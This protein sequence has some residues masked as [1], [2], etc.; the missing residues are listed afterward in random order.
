[1]APGSGRA[2]HQQRAA[3]RPP[4]GP[5]PAG[6]LAAVS[7]AGT[8]RL[9]GGRRPRPTSK[10]STAAISTRPATAARGGVPGGATA[11]ASAAAPQRCRSVRP[12]SCAST[13]PNP[14]RSSAAA[15]P[16]DSTTDHGCR[17]YPIASGE[18][19]SGCPA[20]APAGLALGWQRWRNTHGWWSGRPM[21][22]V[23]RRRRTR[24]PPSTSWSGP[25]D[26][27]HTSVGALDPD[28]PPDCADCRRPP[29]PYPVPAM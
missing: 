6:A 12:R 8:A 25:N 22:P 17:P 29:S 20:A 5:R 1:M 24:P 10:G 13:A 16:A 21:W 7:G 23:A 28:G 15:T 27:C 4:G 14:G 3:S 19:A 18:P 9:A 26:P 11:H 2:L